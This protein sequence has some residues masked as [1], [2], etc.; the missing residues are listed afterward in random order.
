M[1]DNRWKP[2]G[3]VQSFWKHRGKDIDHLHVR[4]KYDG[5]RD[6]HGHLT[7]H[8]V[9]TTCEIVN[10]AKEVVAQGVSIQH[11]DDPHIKR[12]ARR[13]AFDRAYRYLKAAF[14]LQRHVTT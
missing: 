3:H 2:W 7:G 1:S 12:E 9:S 4:F 11:P 5:P 13:Y 8:R 10:P 14:N 6:E